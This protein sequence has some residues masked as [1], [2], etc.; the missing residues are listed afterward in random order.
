M[1]FVVD[2][3]EV[4]EIKMGVDLRRADVRVSEQLLHAAQIPA[5]FKEMG[6]EGVTEKVRMNAQAD[7]LAS[8][9]MRHPRLH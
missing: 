1:S 2:T 7:A 4:L 8:R 3:G 6:S 9:P 5:G